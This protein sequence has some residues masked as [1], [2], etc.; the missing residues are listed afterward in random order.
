MIEPISTPVTV[1]WSL[2]VTF[3]CLSAKSTVAGWPIFTDWAA[4]FS[5]PPPA[6]SPPPV[7]PPVLPPVPPP[8]DEVVPP[9]LPPV[10]L[11]VGVAP[12]ALPVGV[13]PAA[14]A[15]A[16]EVPAPAASSPVPSLP[17][18]SQAVNESA[19]AAATAATVNFMVF[20]RMVRQF[21]GALRGTVTGLPVR[22]RPI[23][24]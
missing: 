20:V 1:I 22:W 10:T 5:L 14:G 9:V 24:K 17:S 12:V 23:Q 19:A 7:P 15:E 8:A 21:L 6:A 4:G 3:A 11:P 2:V 13:P 18:G 16:V